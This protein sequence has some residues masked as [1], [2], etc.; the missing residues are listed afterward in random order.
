MR[1]LMLSGV[2]LSTLC[3]QQAGADDMTDI[4]A[5]PLSVSEMKDR[6]MA[7]RIYTVAAYVVEKYDT[8]PP[9]PSKAVCET[10]V[11]GI[12]VA[13]DNAPRKP[14]TVMNDGLY[15]QTNEA[16]RFQAGVKYLFRIRYRLEQNTAGAWQQTGPE[17]MDFARIGLDG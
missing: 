2:F 14:G 7:P 16:G 12:Y 9:C 10:C 17:L 5:P 11:L 1:S 8:C 13:D 6:I 15:L 3:L 4:T